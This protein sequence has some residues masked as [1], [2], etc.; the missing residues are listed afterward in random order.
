MR[1]IAVGVPRWSAHRDRRPAGGWSSHQ[2]PTRA[3]TRRYGLARLPRVGYGRTARVRIMST[4]SDRLP[5]PQWTGMGQRAAGL[6]LLRQPNVGVSSW[7]TG[8]RR[9]WTA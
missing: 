9:R 3:A 1:T 5:G 7:S 4:G 8:P 6:L 2:R